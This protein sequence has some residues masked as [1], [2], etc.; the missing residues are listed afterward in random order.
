MFKSILDLDSGINLVYGESATGKTTL[1][2]QIAGGV[3]E[4][5]KVVFIDTENGFSI[6]R[7]KQIFPEDYK[8]RLNNIL[9]LRTNNFE[10]QC[11]IFETIKDMKNISLI[12]VDTIGMHYREKVREDHYN[13][14]KKIDRQLKIL[15]ELS[16]NDVK[17]LISNQVYSDIDTKKIQVVGGKMLKNWSSVILKLEKEP[18][19]ILREKPDNKIKEFKILNRGLQLL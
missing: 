7:F 5:K 1:C 6:E 2:L 17:I 10:E 4:K 12:I 19:K 16:K 14:N 9:L 18:R 15:K 8:E 11:K 13:T 3:A